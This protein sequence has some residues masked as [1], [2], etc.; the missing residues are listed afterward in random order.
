MMSFDIDFERE[1]RS[2]DKFEVYYER[3][4]APSLD[5]IDDKKILHAKITLKKRTLDAYYFSDKNGDDGYYDLK[6]ESTKRALMKTPLDVVVV[7]DAYGPRK[8]PVLGYTRM[9][10][11]VDFRARTGTPIMAAGDGI[12]E[13]ASRYG[14]Y[15]NYIRIK[16]NGSYKT[17]YAHLSKYGRGIKK[18]KRVKQG[19]IIGYA[20]S[21]GRVTAAHLHYEVLVNGKQANPLNL[22]L[23]TGKTLKGQEFATFKENQQALSQEIQYSHDINS[24]LKDQKLANN[25]SDI[26][27]S[28]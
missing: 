16:H 9:H 2:G 28:R 12:I 18:G 27:P 3:D 14:S 8:H 19:Q 15:G 21:T 1:I 17:A 6:G 23:P 24:F 26:I 13:R 22:K 25:Q 11:G 5:D 4:Y 20:G 7:T 10:K